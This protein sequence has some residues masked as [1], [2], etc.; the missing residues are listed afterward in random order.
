MPNILRKFLTSSCQL[1]IA[2]L[3]LLG[4]GC[5]VKPDDL[6]SST[7]IDDI[8]VLAEKAQNR[9]AFKEA[10]DF[11]MEADRLYPYSDKSR[12][13]L[14][15]AMKSYHDGSYLSQARLSAKRYL[16]LYPEGPDAP[17][18]QYMI[19]LSFFDAIVDVRRD[20]GAALH[21]V[22]E[23]RK[24][25]LNYPK[26]KYQDLAEKKLRIA[27]SQLAGQ[28]MSVGRYYMKREEYLAAIN[29]FN[30]VASEYRDTIFSVEAFYRLTEAYIA[31]G[32]NNL[33]LENNKVFLKK[34]PKSEWTRK[35]NEL[36]RQL[37][38]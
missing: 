27:H 14:V 22:K 34:F 26:N 3:L 31:L 33:A 25:Q 35:S 17:F 30:V 7:P 10:G 20:Q 15:A 36:A 29:R 37:I 21:A 12:I 11:F 4:M 18:A 16:S 32:M 38:F 2:I 23:F 9:E 8:I 5:T 6:S 1:Y 24:L 19:G 13:A 28:E